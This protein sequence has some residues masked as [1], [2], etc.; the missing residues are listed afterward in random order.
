M[1]LSACVYGCSRLFR[2]VRRSCYM[3]YMQY[4]YAPSACMHV[5]AQEAGKGYASRAGSAPSKAA[6][7]AAEEEGIAGMEAVYQAGARW[8]GRCLSVGAA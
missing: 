3:Q 1:Y 6:A 7:V 4:A 8:G 2:L 5:W